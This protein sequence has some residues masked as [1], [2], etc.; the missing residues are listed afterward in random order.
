MNVTAS[1]PSVEDVEVNVSPNLTVEDLKNLIC[2][3]L[4][5]ESQ[6]SRLLLNGQSISPQLKLNRLDL[7][8]VKL[9]VDYVWARHLILW[10]KE[11]KEDSAKQTC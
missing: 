5:I 4:G 1:I 10:G 8:G 3:K 9:V 6:F 2:R 7:S 11:A